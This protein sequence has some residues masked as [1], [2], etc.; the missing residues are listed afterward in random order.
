M[1]HPAH[2]Q[3]TPLEM[4]RQL[5]LIVNCASLNTQHPHRIHLHNSR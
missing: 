5:S 3:F 2:H 4:F 1:V